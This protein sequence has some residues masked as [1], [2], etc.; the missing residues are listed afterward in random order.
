MQSWLIVCWKVKDW[1]VC[2]NGGRIFFSRRSRI[3][4][5]ISISMISNEVVDV[6]LRV[7]IEEWLV[8]VFVFVFAVFAT[9]F[10]LI[11]LQV[12]KIVNVQVNWRS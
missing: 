1:F 6:I 7:V 10:D 5:S 2:G 4:I 3:R 12:S 8:L 11:V 9:T